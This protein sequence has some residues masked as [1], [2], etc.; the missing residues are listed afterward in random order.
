MIEAAADAPRRFGLAPKTSE[1]FKTDAV[2]RN[3]RMTSRDK[4]LIWERDSFREILKKDIE[5]DPD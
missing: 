1:M 4:Y 2:R 5:K 3:L